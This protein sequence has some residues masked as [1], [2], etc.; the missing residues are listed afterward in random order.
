MTHIRRPN[1]R[2][3]P[4]LDA[5]VN[6]GSCASSGKV[7]Y[8]DQRTAEHARRILAT[9]DPDAARLESYRHGGAGGCGDWHIGHA[10]ARS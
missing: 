4:G 8:L 10:A 9:R 7:R 6:G 3:I 5:L 2:P 1:R